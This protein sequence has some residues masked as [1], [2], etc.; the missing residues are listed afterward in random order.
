MSFEEG[1]YVQAAAFCDQV[2]EDKTGA[3]SLIRIVDVLTHTEAGADP[4]SEMPP[5]PYKLKLVLMLKSG[6]VTGRHELQIIPQLPS[7]ETGD[8][9][10]VT[11]H[12]PGEQ[13]GANVVADIG[14]TFKLEGVYWF[15]VYFNGDLLTR[16]P[17]EMKYVR[18]VTG[19]ARPPAS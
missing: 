9:F 16:M 14:Y 5:V 8:P 13:R 10:P 2:V 12:L 7:G 11:I 18:L 15:H 4:P 6:R 17:F 19:A 1:P 3:L